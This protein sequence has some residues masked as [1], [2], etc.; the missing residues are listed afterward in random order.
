MPS[1]SSEVAP[2]HHL[3][4][5]PSIALLERVQALAG[6]APGV[7]LDLGCGVGERVAALRRSGYDCYGA[8][9]DGELLRAGQRRHPDLAPAPAGNGRLIH[10]DPLEVFDLL[11]PPLSLVFCAEN[12]DGGALARLASLEEA[13]SVL[14]QLWDLT[15]PAGKVLLGLPNF[16]HLAAEAQRVQAAVPEPG[17][18]PQYVE[19]GG[20]ES[21]RGSPQLGSITEEE[22]RLYLPPVSKGSEVGMLELERQYLWPRERRSGAAST[23]PARIHLRMQ[24]RLPEGEHEREHVW[25]VPLLCLTRLRLSELLAANLPAEAFA[26]AQWHGD[27]DGADWS[28]GLALTVLSLG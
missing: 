3:L 8:E 17:D 1:H 27:Y 26:S 2:Y 19:L 20:G 4:A 12:L 24:L 9:L 25:E 6:P 15:R 18:E 23:L 21:R 22:I 28:E 13:A 16:D 11:R 7:L 5:P 14:S 10:G